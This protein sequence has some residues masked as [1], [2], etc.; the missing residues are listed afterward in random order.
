MRYKRLG[1]IDYSPTSLLLVERERTHYHHVACLPG[2]GS[3]LLSVPRTYFPFPVAQKSSS[4]V[5]SPVSPDSYTG[6]FSFF[7]T[8]KA[9]NSGVDRNEIGE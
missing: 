8:V 6:R 2:V 9:R 1:S 7:F 3:V 5:L 4:E